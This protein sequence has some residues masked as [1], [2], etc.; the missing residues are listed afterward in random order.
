MGSAGR[1][2]KQ[3]HDGKES[4]LRKGPFYRARGDGTQGFGC[5]FEHKKRLGLIFYDGVV[6][7]AF[8]GGNRT[9]ADGVCPDSR[10]K[11]Q[12]TEGQIFG[13]NIVFV[14]LKDHFQLWGPVLAGWSCHGNP[15]FLFR[16]IGGES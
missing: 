7:N 10:P 6:K 12:F 15:V 2:F 16:S 4:L 5:L 9:R 11:S 1:G 13:R 14:R 3:F 8:E